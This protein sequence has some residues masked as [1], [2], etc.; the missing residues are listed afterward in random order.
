MEQPLGS[1]GDIEEAKIAFEGLAVRLNELYTKE[2]EVGLTKE[3]RA[4]IKLILNNAMIVDEVLRGK[5][6]PELRS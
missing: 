3:E 5:V 1:A 4:E 2:D 6:P